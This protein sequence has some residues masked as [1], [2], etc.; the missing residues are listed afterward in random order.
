MN[1]LVTLS[2]G[3]KLPMD[4]NGSLIIQYEY[5]M[6]YTPAPYLQVG[7]TVVEACYGK[8]RPFYGFIYTK[9]EKIE[10]SI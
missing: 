9:I 8:E 7:Q 10:S 4:E 6:D 5:E 2:D 3:R 1:Y